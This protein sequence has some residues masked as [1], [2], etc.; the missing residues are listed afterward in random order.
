MVKGG[1]G[2]HAQGQKIGWGELTSK[3][4]GRGKHKVEVSFEGEKKNHSSVSVA[5]RKALHRWS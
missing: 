4:E 2:S 5:E 3:K 1:E